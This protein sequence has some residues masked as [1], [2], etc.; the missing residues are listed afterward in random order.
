[1]DYNKF[2]KAKYIYICILFNKVMT[3]KKVLLQKKLKYIYFQPE[4]F[5]DIIQLHVEL[6]AIWIM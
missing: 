2:A 3:D 5:E 4:F 6:V 1:M